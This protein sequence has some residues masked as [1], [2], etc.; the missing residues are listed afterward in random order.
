M[1]ADVAWCAGLVHDH[2]ITMAS[3]SSG[4]CESCFGGGFLGG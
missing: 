4:G 3:V 2:V 1:L